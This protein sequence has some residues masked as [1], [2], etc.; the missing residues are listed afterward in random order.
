MDWQWLIK[1]NYKVTINV[2]GTNPNDVLF[3]ASVVGNNNEEII[4]ENNDLITLDASKIDDII[5][6]IF[7]PETASA[8]YSDPITD[9][10]VSLSLQNIDNSYVIGIAYDVTDKKIVAI[11]QQ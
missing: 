6:T 5:G 10:S 1:N 4:I 2:I 3:N 7:T 11:E 8:T 9:S